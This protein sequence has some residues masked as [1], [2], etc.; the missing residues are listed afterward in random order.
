MHGDR[1]GIGQFLRRSP[2]RIERG[3]VGEDGGVEERIDDGR[4]N[5]KRLQGGAGV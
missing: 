1:A 4:W 3:V 5:E 2:Q